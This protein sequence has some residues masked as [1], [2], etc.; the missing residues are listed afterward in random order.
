MPQSC[1]FL[2]LGEDCDFADYVAL[3][4]FDGDSDG[5]DH[6]A[7]VYFLVYDGLVL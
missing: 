6:L 1:S 4:G 5:S 7:G 2:G 3:P